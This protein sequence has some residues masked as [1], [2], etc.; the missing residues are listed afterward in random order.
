M[1]LID[2]TD[3]IPPLENTEDQEQRRVGV[4]IE[5]AGLDPNV[6]TTVIKD[7]FGGEAIEKSRYEFIVSD[8]SLGEFKVELDAAYL[9]GLAENTDSSDQ[10]MDAKILDNLPADLLTTAAEQFVPWEIVGPPIAVSDLSSLLPLG[11]QLR[12]AGALGTRQ[13]ARY[14]FGVHLN[15]ELPKLDASTILNYFRAFLC[16]YE[17]IA[18]QE[19]VDLL[20]RLTP[21][22]NHFEVDYIRHV[23]DPGYA[24]DIATLIDDYLLANPTRNRSMDMLPLFAY[25]D[26]K[27]VRSQMDDPRIKPRPTLHYRLP[28]CDIDNPEWNLD[29][30]WNSWLQVEYLAADETRVLDI[31]QAYQQELQRMTRLLDKQWLEQTQRWLQR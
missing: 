2:R 5:L 26:E 17:W 19:Q 9:K 11:D 6:M 16:L 25:L 30:P 10:N 8:T 20:R 23:I 28:N 7:L 31:C 4:E 22:I 18:E 21:Y 1:R 24:P 3:W 13:A 29:H 12:Q 27:R 15:P 14:A